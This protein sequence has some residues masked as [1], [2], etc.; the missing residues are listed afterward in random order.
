MCRLL[1]VWFLDSTCL[2]QC[3]R[4]ATVIAATSPTELFRVDQ[5]TFRYILQSQTQQSE[6]EKI[7]L[8][9]SVD[10]LKTLTSTDL[11][12]LSSVMIPRV[13]QKDEL[14][15]KKGDMGDAFYVIQEGNVLVKDISVGAT[16]YEDQTLGAGEYFGERSLATSEPRAAN[17]VALN[18]G[19]AFSIDRNT[20][21]KVLGKMS[22]LILKAQ[23]A[24]RLAG[25]KALK[26]AKL[27]PNQISS[28]AALIEDKRYRADKEIMTQGERTKAALYFVRE[29]RIEILEH[30]GD[31]DD[32][33]APLKVIK[34]VE[35]GGYFGEAIYRKHRRIKAPY[36]ARV[37]DGKP[38]VCGVLSVEKSREIFDTGLLVDD[39]ATTKVSKPGD[40]AVSMAPVYYDSTDESGDE[41][42]MDVESLL[43]TT[44]Y[45]ENA[46]LSDLQRHV[47]LGEGTFGQVWLVSESGVPADKRVPFALKIQSKRDLVHE[48]QVKAV[49][50]EKNIMSEVRQHPFLIN[51][52]KTYQDDRFVYIL[53]EMI[54]GG[55]M[56]SILHREEESG[57]DEPQ[58]K[59]YGLCVADALAYMHRSKIVYRDL[60]PENI[61]IDAKGYPIIIDFGF[62]KHVP[63][64]TYTLCGTPG[65]STR[66]S[67]A[68]CLCQRR[69]QLNHISPLSCFTVSPS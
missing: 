66:G 40:T 52:V 29:G 67:V 54:Q 68:R 30:D 10:F 22:A 21:E 28:L 20:F 47:I 3:P 55:E 58:A 48:G 61:M 57:F 64:K 24:R 62:A 26:R 19:V 6:R 33:D 43:P 45:N 31:A 39:G 2:L 14:L 12:K 63:E 9:E 49:I 41:G 18:K 53:L 8:L 4:A 25:V 36:T 44:L 17:V 23:D 35:P 38:C 27:D 7:A 34:D 42:F 37:A 5:N 32:S 51:L 13:F 69:F 1:T 11:E 46:T 50:Q 15:V 65:V 60:K 56:F 16:T 59:F